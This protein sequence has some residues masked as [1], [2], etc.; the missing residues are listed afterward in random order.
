MKIL[1][2]ISLNKLSLR[3]SFTYLTLVLILIGFGYYILNTHNLGFNTALLLKKRIANYNQLISVGLCD[4][5]SEKF[6]TKYSRTVERNDTVL[7]E[8]HELYCTEKC[9]NKS[10]PLQ[11]SLCKFECQKEENTSFSSFCSQRVSSWRQNT[12]E[13]IVFSNNNRADIKIIYV[14]QDNKSQNHFERWLYENGDWYLDYWPEGN[15]L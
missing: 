11:K 10:T 14:N 3:K 7:S 13:N 9:S 12:L 15:P 4:D 8:R 5:V 1:K 6:L 2:N